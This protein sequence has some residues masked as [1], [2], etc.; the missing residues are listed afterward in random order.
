[1]KKVF[2]I[3]LSIL[4]LCFIF[5]NSSQNGKESN[6][7]SNNVVEKVITDI[8]ESDISI[9]T[10][11]KAHINR[12][13]FNLVIRKFAHGFEF[14]MLSIIL[15]RVFSFFVLNKNNAMIYSLFLV[16]IA[17]VSDEFFQLYISGRN[18]SI[19]DVVIDFTGGVIGIIVIRTLILIKNKYM[20]RSI[21]NIITLL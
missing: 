16:L 5:F 7:R 12:K 19:K 18:S 13:E 1:M 10:I 2:Y 3:F 20:N 17:A 14:G 9:P 6:V 21:K 11:S 4:C 15:F 8:K